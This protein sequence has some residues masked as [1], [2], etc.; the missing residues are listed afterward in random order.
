MLFHL[1]VAPLIGRS[2]PHSDYSGPR[3]C[4]SILQSTPIKRRGGLM[5]RMASFIACLTAV[6]LMSVSLALAGGRHHVA[7]RGGFAFQ[8]APV[9]APH[10]RVFFRERAFAAV[11][12][13]PAILRAP[14]LVRRAPVLFPVPA[15]P[16]AV[17]GDRPAAGHRR[18]ADRRGTLRR[19]AARPVLTAPWH[20]YLGSSRWRCSWA[21]AA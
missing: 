10:A 8:G 6:L 17:A 2:S 13:I 18:S 7:V 16:R 9:F 3:R 14:R 15:A 5:K 19:R 20:E 1:A 4:G 12:P 11:L 21:D